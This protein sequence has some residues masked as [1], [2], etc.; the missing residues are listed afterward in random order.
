MRCKIVC[1]LNEVNVLA[2][3]VNIILTLIIIEVS[4]GKNRIL[5]C[6]KIMTN[7]SKLICIYT[8]KLFSMSKYVHS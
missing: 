3:E 8:W 1:K 2:K 7:L 6:T 5:K 4:Q